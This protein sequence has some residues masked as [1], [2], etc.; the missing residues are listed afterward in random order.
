MQTQLGA[1]LTALGMALNMILADEGN[2]VKSLVS[3]LS[4]T[5]KILTDLFHSFS[6]QRSF[7]TPQLNTTAMNIA[8]TSC[9]DA[10][11]FVSDFGE[12]LKAAKEVEKSSRDLK[13]NKASQ[14][15]ITKPNVD[16]KIQSN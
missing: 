1:G 8:R 3:I 2:F 10:N 16:R 13:A 5:G 14:S 6:I 12:R 9:I 15:R 11:L 4:D 7:L